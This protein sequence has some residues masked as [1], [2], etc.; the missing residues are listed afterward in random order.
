[1][2]NVNILHLNMKEKIYYITL[3]IMCVKD[4][5]EYGE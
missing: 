4:K 1:M 5:K 3:L 2:N